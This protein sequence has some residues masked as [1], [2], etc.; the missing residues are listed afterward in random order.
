MG[1]RDGTPGQPHQWPRVLSR[2]VPHTGLRPPG[3][4]GA[5]RLPAQHGRVGSWGGTHRGLQ[6]GWGPPWGQPPNAHSGAP[7]TVHPPLP[8]SPLW[9]LPLGG[10][11]STRSHHGMHPPPSPWDEH[12]S[13]GMG[14]QYLRIAGGIWPPE[15]TPGAQQQWGGGGGGGTPR[16]ELWLHPQGCTGRG[17]KGLH[18]KQ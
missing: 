16:F 8:G 5:H 6:L 14:W 15:G 7:H 12:L 1:H 17:G 4:P 3:A 2:A 10:I 13:V 11:H 18:W 9:V